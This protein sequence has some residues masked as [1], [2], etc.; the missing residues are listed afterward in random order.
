MF[1]L[2]KKINRTVNS[3][4]EFISKVYEPPAGPTLLFQKTYIPDL[5]PAK[6]EPLIKE[7]E[8]TFSERLMELIRERKL[9]EVEVY[10]KAD[11]DRRVFSKIRSFSDYRPTK[12]TAI[13]LCMSMKLS[14]EETQD[15]LGRASLA[16]S[17]CNKQDI[18]A[19]YFFK[20]EIYDVR[21]YKEVLY[22]FGLI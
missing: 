9:D 16:L 1:F 13:L 21:L 5:V 20:N 8:P 19:E 4:N 15:L 22:K 14:L 18:I 3:I 17:R 7:L 12:D 6:I 2:N 11:I 10:K